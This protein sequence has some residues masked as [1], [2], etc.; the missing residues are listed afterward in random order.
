MIE[1]GLWAR[2]YLSFK[3]ETFCHLVRDGYL[4][5]FLKAIF[6]LTEVTKRS[7]LDGALS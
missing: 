6:H 2:Y 5:E 7:W 4:A 1:A 3:I